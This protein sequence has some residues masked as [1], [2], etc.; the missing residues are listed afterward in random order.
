M[1]GSV[2]GSVYNKDE[3]VSPCRNHNCGMELNELQ[4]HE[5]ELSKKFV[6]L[7]RPN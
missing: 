7:P 3:S 1:S 6:A 4:R 5:M 2:R